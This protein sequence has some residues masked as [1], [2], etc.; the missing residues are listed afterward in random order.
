MDFK[1]NVIKF[2]SI[3]ALHRE[4]IDWPWRARFGPRA[5]NWRPL[6]QSNNFQ[7]FFSHHGTWA[8]LVG[9]QLFADG[10]GIHSG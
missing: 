9:R 4:P 3:L 6:V 7:E 2:F 1:E 8:T 5:A 10:Q